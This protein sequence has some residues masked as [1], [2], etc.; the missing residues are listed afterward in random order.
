MLNKAVPT[1]A[2]A[3]PA[4]VKKLVLWVSIV[5]AAIITL[6]HLVSI[7]QGGHDQKRS[8]KTASL[9]LSMPANGNSAPVS[10][11]PGYAVA[12]TGNGFTTHCV[13]SDG[14][15]GVVGSRVHPCRSG[16]M[17]YEYVHDTTGKT[18]TVTYAFRR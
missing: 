16:P 13:Y 15:E 1:P 14:S 7:V 17:L 18:N 9:M 8:E 10:A 6:S 3:V 5:L 12:F 4:N 11:P 2:I